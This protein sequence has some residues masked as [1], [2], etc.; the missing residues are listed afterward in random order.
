ML[1][2]IA[3]GKLL[4]SSRPEDASIASAQAGH[5]CTV[6]GATSITAVSI[7]PANHRRHRIVVPPLGII[8]S[9]SDNLAS[10]ERQRPQDASSGR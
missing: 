1:W 3:S 4:D 2:F 5:A 9:A 8:L 6:R 7:A 10:R